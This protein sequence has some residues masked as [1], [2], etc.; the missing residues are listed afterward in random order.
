[1]L[2]DI[3]DDDTEI[4][5]V[6]RYGAEEVR[7]AQD[8]RTPECKRRGPQYRLALVS[9]GGDPVH[10]CWMIAPGSRKAAPEAIIRLEDGRSLKV[11][12]REVTVEAT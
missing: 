12:L 9:R 2:S 3:T 4:I 10:G 5:L 11:P 8:M 7:L 1:M 6:T